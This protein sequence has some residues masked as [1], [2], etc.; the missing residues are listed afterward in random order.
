MGQQPIRPPRTWGDTVTDNKAEIGGQWMT[1][2]E[3]ATLL[4]ISLEAAKRRAARGGWP[5]RLHNEDGRARILVPPNAIPNVTPPSSPG[6]QDGKGNVTPAV[7]ALAAALDAAR[8]SG[9]RQEAELGKLRDALRIAEVEAATNR[10]EVRRL[11]EMVALLRG[12][13]DHLHEAHCLALQPRFGSLADRLKALFTRK[14][15]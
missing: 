5:R 14:L 9:S 15:P 13:L 12:E 10:G 11:E 1:Y 6:G 2:V 7:A 4:G 3:A 8:E